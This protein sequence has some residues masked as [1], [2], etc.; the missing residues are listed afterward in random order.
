MPT[1]GA[2]TKNFG[3]I[4]Q[5]FSFSV[6]ISLTF[7]LRVTLKAHANFLSTLLFYRQ[8][9]KFRKCGKFDN[10]WIIFCSFCLFSPWPVVISVFTRINCKFTRKCYYALKKIL[11]SFT[12]M[13]IAPCFRTCIL[14][15]SH[16]APTTA[17]V[18]RTSTHC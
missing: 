14:S 7:R 2:E 4:R 15:I 16:I 1:G 13:T 3:Q 9:K 12:F 17:L 5:N 11:A 18:R 6:K 10:V 8:E